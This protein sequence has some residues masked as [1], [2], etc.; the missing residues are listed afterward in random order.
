MYLR[1]IYK[2]IIHKQTQ[3]WSFMFMDVMVWHT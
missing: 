2:L 1:L 3:H